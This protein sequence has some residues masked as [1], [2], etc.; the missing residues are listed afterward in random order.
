M[1]AV[2]PVVVEDSAEIEE[3]GPRFALVDL[4]GIQTPAFD[5]SCLSG[6]SGTFL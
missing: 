4:T 2:D 6:L 1:S 5:A 3:E